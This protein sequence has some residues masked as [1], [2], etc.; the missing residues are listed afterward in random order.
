MREGTP[1]SPPVTAPTGLAAESEATKQSLAFDTDENKNE[2]GV[3]DYPTIFN[4][5]GAPVTAD[6]VDDEYEFSTPRIEAVKDETQKKTLRAG[7]RNYARGIFDLW[8]VAAGK[9]STKLLNL[10]HVENMNLTRWGGPDTAFRFTC[11]G[12][13][14]KGRIK[15]RILV[16]EMALTQQP[17]SQPNTARGIEASK[18]TPYGLVRD[19]GV[20]DFVWDKVLR[21]LGKFQETMIMRIRDVTFE[22]STA[23]VGKSGEAAEFI[24]RFKKGSGWTRRIVLYK[25]MVDADDTTFAF[26]LAHEIG[27]AINSAPTQGAASRLKTDVHNDP[28][29]K[30]AAKRDGGRAKAITSY[31]RQSDSEFFAECLAMFVQQQQTF[32]TLRPNLAQ[33]FAEYELGALKD[34]KLN[35][36]AKSSSMFGPGSLGI[37]IGPFAPGEGF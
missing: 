19:A 1:G 5:T 8:P 6:N 23:Q 32:Y 26:T 20:P 16:E 21:S 7:L 12:S 15:V 9:A 33:W 22:T 25:K 2:K 31:G 30:A 36:Y 17:M 3:T 29:F 37:G 34:P 10:V 24:D 14:P 4:L 11:I 27:H 35:P 13:R 18:A 28:G